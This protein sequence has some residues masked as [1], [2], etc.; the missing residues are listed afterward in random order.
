LTYQ[1]WLS[2]AARTPRSLHVVY[3]NTSLMTKARSHSIVP[4]ITCTSSNVVQT[5][6]TAFAEIPDLHVWFGPDTYMGRNLGR[7]FEALSRMDDAAIA[8]VHP[9]HSRA[10]IASLRERF[11][12][13]EQGHCVV[14]HMFGAD[15][16]RRVREEESDAF[17]TA[18]LEV[19]GEMF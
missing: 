8:K 17:V 19:P 10:T 1:A 14:H 11:A 9:A 6:L 16:T 15:V 12:W 7:L 3:I 2:K 13:F 4:T 5:I 18:H